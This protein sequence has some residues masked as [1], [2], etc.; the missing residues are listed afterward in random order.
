MGPFKVFVR[1]TL[2]M[3]LVCVIAVIITTYFLYLDEMSQFRDRLVESANRMKGSVESI[4]EYNAAH[5]EDHIKYHGVVDRKHYIKDETISQVRRIGRRHSEIGDI[6]ITIAYLEGD[7][8]KWIA[9]SHQDE[10]LYVPIP[11]GHNWAIPMQLALRGGHS[12]TRGIDYSGKEVLAAYTYIPSVGIGIVAKSPIKRIQN[13]F[14]KG[15]MVAVAPAFGIVILGVVLFIRITSPVIQRLETENAIHKKVAEER[16]NIRKEYESLIYNV[17]GMIYTGDEKWGVKIISGSEL[18]SGY[19]EED[20]NSLEGKWLSL[21]HPEDKEEVYSNGLVIGG[22][23]KSV[24]QQYR[25]IDKS[26]VVHWVE[27]HKTIVVNGV[28]GG[29]LIGILFDITDRIEAAEELKKLNEHQRRVSKMEAIGDFA[30]GIAHDFNNALTPIVGNCDIMLH[31]LDPNTPCRKNILQILAAAETATLLVHRMQSFVTGDTSIDNLQALRLPGCLQEAFDFLRSM[32]PAS[33]KMSM[34]LAPA[35]HVV[36]ATDVTLRQ[37]L[38][39]VCRNA[40][41]SMKRGNGE[42][43]IDVSNDVVLVEKYG[44]AKGKYV[45]IEVEDNGRGMSPEVLERAL[46]PYFTTKKPGEGTGIGLSV[47]NGIV[48]SYEGFIRL[49]SEVGKGS[50]VVIYIPAI[51]DA[52]DR[53]KECKIYEPIPAGNK[54]RILLVDDEDLIIDTST[55]ILESLNYEVTGFNSSIAAL[56]EI[57][58]HPNDYDVLVT[59]LTM[60]EMTGVILIKEIQKVKRDIKIILC[61]GLGS[62]GKYAKEL[63]GDSLGAYITK[64]VTRRGYGEVLAKVLGRSK[65][66]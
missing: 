38:M 25:I 65:N 17:P 45:K 66:G 63:F 33:I 28:R 3:T 52:A 23:I 27:D 51:D 24:V 37:I 41:Q 39:N 32:T 11:M 12:T 46:D 61:S 22:N 4:I 60:P 36:A 49:Y 31:E 18:V 15:A 21:V 1:L 14:I 29:R 5:S 47:V 44:V 54:E 2:I 57:Q 40:A 26:G 19:T 10:V 20:I 35:L 48:T 8:I 64:P 62:N 34:N 13:R 55:T 16:E 7:R 43:T 59:D 30:S 50:K 53:A 9:Q 58:K 56:D 6:E 42:I